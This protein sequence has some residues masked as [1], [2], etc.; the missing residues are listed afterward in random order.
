M[1]KC[2]AY[3]R[4]KNGFIVKTVFVYIGLHSDRSIDCSLRIDKSKLIKI[5][6]FFIRDWYASR[7][8]LSLKSSFVRRSIAT[9][10]VL[11]FSYRL[12][13]MTCSRRPASSSRYIRLTV[14]TALSVSLFSLLPNHIV[15]KTSSV[16]INIL[17]TVISAT[18]LFLLCSIIR[19]PRFV[20]GRF[21]LDGR[22]AW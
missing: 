21:H 10:I 22:N 8:A 18:V 6:Q 4:F 16:A 13:L 5:I 17:P 19:P 11:I 3:L 2:H 7:C 15:A 9:R 20:W 12:F 1:Y 14:R